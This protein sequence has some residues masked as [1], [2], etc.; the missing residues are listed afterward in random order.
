MGEDIGLLTNMID[1]FQEDAPELL[2][3]LAAALEENDGQE[4]TRFAHSLKG[5][6]AIYEATAAVDTALQIEENCRESDLTSARNSLP[7][8]HKQIDE[9]SVALK[10]WQKDQQS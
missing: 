7:T 9:L 1:Y 4:A 5:M 10:A 3:K 8:L 6:C 2:S